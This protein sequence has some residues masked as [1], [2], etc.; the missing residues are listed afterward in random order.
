MFWRTAA[1]SWFLLSRECVITVTPAR[2][3]YV[4]IRQHTSACVSVITVMPARS[5]Y[6]PDIRGVTPMPHAACR[7]PHDKKKAE[8]LK[9]KKETAQQKKM[10]AMS[11]PQEKA[12]TIKKRL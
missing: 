1:V 9:K 5:A 11:S 12:Q 3:S 2:S 6:R 8:A 4:S 10:P 7:M